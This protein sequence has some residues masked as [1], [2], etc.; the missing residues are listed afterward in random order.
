VAFSGN[1]TIFA[2][3][4][5]DIVWG[6]EGDDTIW[7]SSYSRYDAWGADKVYGG[8]GNDTIWYRNSRS[9]LK[10][11][12]DD[13]NVTNGPGTDTIVAGS[14]HDVIVGGKGGDTVW[15]GAGHDFIYGEYTSRNTLEEGAGEDKLYG[16]SGNDTI[17]AGAGN[18]VL[19]GGA[20]R[21]YLSGGGGSDKF[22]VNLG[23]TGLTNFYM[24]V[25]FDFNSAYDSIDVSRTTSGWY[26]ERYFYSFSDA[27]W[28][29]K[30]DAARG[31][32]AQLMNEKTAANEFKG[33]DYVF[34]SDHKD[35]FLFADL[36]DDGYMDTGIILMGLTSLN[37][38]NVSDII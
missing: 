8:E 1:D 26:S 17:Y 21:D 24:D 16:E 32:A 27:T 22:V 29:Q 37:Q 23:D 31:A 11:W 19:A 4:G 9:D 28:D 33:H 38:F 7:A 34:V 25:I 3:G 35:G 13:E 6:G 5:D 36:N 18:D 10:I 14:G 30:V 12:G 2:N 15:G 20:D